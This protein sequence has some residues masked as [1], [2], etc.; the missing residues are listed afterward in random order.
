MVPLLL[1]TSGLRVG[2]KVGANYLFRYLARRGVTET[3]KQFGIQIK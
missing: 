2:A 3:K 1:I